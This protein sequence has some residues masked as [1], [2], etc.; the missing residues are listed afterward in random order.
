MRFNMAEPKTY[1]PNSS[2]KEVRFDD[3]GAILKISFKS[4]ELVDFI[5]VNTN[6]K[7]YFNIGVSPRREAG[8]YGDTHSVWLDT[9]KPKPQEGRQA[10][11]PER[12]RPTAQD[13]PPPPEE[14]DVPF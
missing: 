1:I 9:W 11:P 5:R 3:G 13:L 6:D 8:R 12:E 14:Q 10:T 4:K 7:G 2:A